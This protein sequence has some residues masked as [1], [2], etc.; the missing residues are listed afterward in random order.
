MTSFYDKAGIGMTSLRTRGRLLERLEEK[1]ITDQNVLKAISAIPRHLFID[2]AIAHSAY[3]D[4]ALPIGFG[5]TISQPY[6]V[7]RMSAALLAGSTRLS[8]VLE[9]GTGSGYQSAVLSHIA[10]EVYTI[11]RIKSLQT[12]ARRVLKDI[13]CDNVYFKHGDGSFGWPE[14]GP[15]DGIIAT[16]SPERTPKEWM[17]QLADGGR[18]I[19]PVDM[20]EAQELRLISRKGNEFTSVGLE[21]VRFVPLVSGT[22]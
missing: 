18:L 15:F 3:E 20:G 13:H 12:K 8:R 17:E 21:M 5:Q 1:G 9:I 16:A 7:A 22:E 2:E 19:L 10:D 11:E 6:I 14:K 4:T